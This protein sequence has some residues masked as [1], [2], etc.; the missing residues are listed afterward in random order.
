MFSKLEEKFF[1]LWKNCKE[2]TVTENVTVKGKNH[3]LTEC[4]NSFKYAKLCKTEYLI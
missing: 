3:I 1:S 4:F 2:F